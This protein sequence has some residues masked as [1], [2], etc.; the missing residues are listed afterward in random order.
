MILSPGTELPLLE[1]WLWS[2]GEDYGL[3][4]AGL[5]D[6]A[7]DQR[8]SRAGGQYVNSNNRETVDYNISTLSAASLSS[9]E[10]K[11]IFTLS[12]TKFSSLK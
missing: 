6:R 8:V 5:G 7:T 4:R 12:A 9:V 2:W 3:A 10:M 11:G 1:A